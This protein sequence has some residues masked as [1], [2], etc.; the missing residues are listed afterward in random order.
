MAAIRLG[1]CRRYFSKVAWIIDSGASVHMTGNE[2][3]MLSRIPCRPMRLI[4]ADGGICVFHEVGDAYF[5]SSITLKSVYFS[6]S[7]IDPLISLGKLISDCKL[8]ARFTPQDVTFKHVASKKIVA[9]G[10][11]SKRDNLYRI[12]GDDS[13]LGPRMRMI[14]HLRKLIPPVSCHV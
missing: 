9:Y 11:I 5:S 3:V 12:Y 1:M 4:A 10:T 2:S 14:R 7:C 6:A 8:E 13:D